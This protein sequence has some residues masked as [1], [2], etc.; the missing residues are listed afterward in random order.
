VKTV[1]KAAFLYMRYQVAM[2]F[3]VAGKR[4]MDVCV[5]LEP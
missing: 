3:P 2:Q 5:L 4:E 1:L